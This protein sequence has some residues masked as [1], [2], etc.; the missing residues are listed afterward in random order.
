MLELTQQSRYPINRHNPGPEGISTETEEA[1]HQGFQMLA[2]K[3][4]AHFMNSSCEM[5]HDMIKRFC[6]RILPVTFLSWMCEPQ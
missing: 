4:Q 2:K 5:D 3:M 1:Q 6:E